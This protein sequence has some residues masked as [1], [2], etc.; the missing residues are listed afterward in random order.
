[1]GVELYV[2]NEVKTERRTIQIKINL[3]LIIQT[4]RVQRKKV[5]ISQ[6][7]QHVN[8]TIQVL[9][10]YNN[11][12]NNFTEDIQQSRTSHRNLTGVLKCIL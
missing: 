7:P 11:W 10:I 8:Q 1:M 9:H 6:N 2:I 3:A 5:K 12:P 4:F